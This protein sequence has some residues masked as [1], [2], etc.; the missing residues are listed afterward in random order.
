MTNNASEELKDMRKRFLSM[1]GIARKAGKLICGTPLICEALKKKKKPCLVIVACDV[2]ENTRK[3]LTFKSEFYKVQAI[4]SDVTKDELSHI[5]GKDCI[6]AAVA[7]TDSGLAAELLK[8]SGKE[9]SE[10]KEA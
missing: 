5:V 2:S 1:L 8:L 7:L 9:A 3:T 6:I 10:I 4:I